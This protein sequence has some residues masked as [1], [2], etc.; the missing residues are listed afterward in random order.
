[1]AIAHMARQASAADGGACRHMARA[2]ARARRA[3][4]LQSGATIGCMFEPL[5]THQFVCV[6]PPIMH[7]RCLNFLDIWTCQFVQNKRWWGGKRKV[8]NGLPLAF[9]WPSHWPSISFHWPSLGFPFAIGLPLAFH[10]PFIGLPL[11]CHWPYTG[12]TLAFHLP[13]IGLP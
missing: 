8:N 9:H 3:R 12:L 13:S 11:A 4:L 2:R 6:V 10:W 5:S 7:R 1:M